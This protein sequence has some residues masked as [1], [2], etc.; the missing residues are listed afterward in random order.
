MITCFSSAQLFSCIW[1]FA[2]AWTAAHQA[3][4]SIPTPRTYSNSC[5]SSRWCHP[6]ISSSVIPF[7]SYCQSF[8][9]SRS[10]PRS[11]FFASGGQRIGVSASASVLPM[12]IQDWSPLGWTSRMDIVVQGTLKSL[13]QHHS[14]KTSILQCSAFFI[15]HLSQ[16]YVTTG[17]TI[18]LTRQTFVGKV[19]FLLF[20]MLSRLF[21]AFLPRSKCLLVSWLQSPS[22]VI[23]SPEIKSDTVCIVSLS[24]CHEV[25]GP[26][27]MILVF[28]VLSFKP[29]FPLSSLTFIKR[30][31]V[32]SSLSA[33]RV[34]PA[35]CVQVLS[36]VWL[37]N[38]TDCSPLGS[39][40]HGIFQARILECVA[41]SFSRG[42][43]QPKD[44]TH[45]SYVSCIGRQVLY[46]LS[47]CGIPQ[48]YSAICISEVINISPGN[49]DSSLCFIQLSISHDVICIQVK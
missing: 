22:T 27:A 40:V 28:W 8:P 49:L 2:T 5:P 29:A 21:I 24:I 39:S 36:C 12:N 30:H 9:A 31:S 3:S 25:M 4:L 13:L 37:C 17:K 7:S 16:P 15:V 19:M 43:S 34:E 46:Q 20:N 47:H 48:S 45:V 10:L 44:W 18:T 11:Q 35:A 1:L 6:I 38:P 23:W 14:S 42:Y 32:S 33:I 26:N 41:I